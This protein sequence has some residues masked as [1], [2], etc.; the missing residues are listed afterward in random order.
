MRRDWLTTQ[1]SQT[2]TIR[3]QISCLPFFACCLNDASMNS[4]TKNR[5]DSRIVFT[6]AIVRD[7]ISRTSASETNLAFSSLGNNSMAL[8]HTHG[9]T[10]HY[11]LHDKVGFL[12]LVFQWFRFSF[13]F[14]F[15]FPASLFSLVM[16]S[17][18]PKL[19]HSWLPFVR[20]KLNVILL[21]LLL[22]LV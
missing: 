21:R 17:L 3:N 9:D 16:I 8:S 19:F 7:S 20:G 15:A 10:V 13:D 5:R 11:C 12:N 2:L 1:F 18:S 4:M 14:F 6:I 22:P